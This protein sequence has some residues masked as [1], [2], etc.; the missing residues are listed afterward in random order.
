[1]IEKQKESPSDII[2]VH[3]VKL[4]QISGKVSDAFPSWLGALAEEDSF[5]RPPAIFY[6]KSLEAQLHDFKSKIPPE[7]KENSRLF[8]CWAKVDTATWL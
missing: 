5:I 1:V 4:H 6:L 3:I 7:L 2:L 8:S